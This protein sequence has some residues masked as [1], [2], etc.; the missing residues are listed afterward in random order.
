MY[1][2]GGI[3]QPRGM[4]TKLARKE[5]RL[6]RDNRAH[7]FM[8]SSGGAREEFAACNGL[9]KLKRQVSVLPLVQ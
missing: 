4:R 6:A 2:I 1:K 8:E 9:Y 7:D 3:R 5:N